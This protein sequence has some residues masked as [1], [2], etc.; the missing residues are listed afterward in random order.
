ML[1]IE[2]YNGSWWITGSWTFDFREDL[3][4][5]GG[6]WNPKE[7]AWVI[8]LAT[9]VVGLQ[10]KVNARK[11]EEKLKRKEQQRL[12]EENFKLHPPYWVCC[13]KAEIIDK[14][15]QHTGC[16]QHGFRVRG[17]LFTGD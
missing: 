9:C 8:P 2:E 12:E 4:Y 3:K 5:L 10:E 13:G 6:K 14:K 16:S 17:F 1:R 11:E 15:R 7:R